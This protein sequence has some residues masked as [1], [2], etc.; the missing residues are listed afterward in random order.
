M[1]ID[2]VITFF[3]LYIKILSDPYFKIKRLLTIYVD[4]FFCWDRHSWCL[5]NVL[6]IPRDNKK[7]FIVPLLW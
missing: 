5:F 2:I 1:S 4:L 6:S 7:T 3:N